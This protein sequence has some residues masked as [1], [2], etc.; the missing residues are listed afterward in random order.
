MVDRS[1]DGSIIDVCLG[2]L[3]NLELIERLLVAFPL[4]PYSPHP[5]RD[6]SA[7]HLISETSIPFSFHGFGFLFLFY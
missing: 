2:G 5:R 7:F 3:M 1:I 4:M 6:N